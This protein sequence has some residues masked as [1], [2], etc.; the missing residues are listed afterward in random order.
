MQPKND[1]NRIWMTTREAAEAL[2]LNPGTLRVLRMVDRQRGIDGW[3][4][5]GPLGVRY[6]KF[7]GAYR[8][9]VP[10]ILSAGPQA[11]LQPEPREAA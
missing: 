9:F 3:N 8:Y 2:S 5:V 4:K 1:S 10:D 6:R 7:G 11:E